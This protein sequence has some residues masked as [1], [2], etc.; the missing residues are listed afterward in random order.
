MG[1]NKLM[2]TLDGRSYEKIST[3]PIETGTHFVY[4]RKPTELERK[5]QTTI[6]ELQNNKKIDDN[7]KTAYIKQLQNIIY[8]M[9][10][11]DANPI[12][13]RK[14]EINGS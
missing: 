11:N 1:G 6:N 9:Q 8:Q 3:K 5:L 12:W 2:C 4:E 14:E 7:W 13:E 10:I